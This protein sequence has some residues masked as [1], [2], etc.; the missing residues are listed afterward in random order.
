MEMAVRLRRECCIQYRPLVQFNGGVLR[1]KTLFERFLY[2]YFP[3]LY[4]LC[5]WIHPCVWQRERLSVN[6][7]VGSEMLTIYRYVSEWDQRRS[8]GI[9]FG[10]PIVISC[11]VSVTYVHKLS[12]DD[13]GTVFR[14]AFLP[15]K[16]LQLRPILAHVHAPHFMHC[17][18]ALLPRQ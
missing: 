13:Y 17:I 14:L 7:V 3:S 10:W 11:I 4:S 8:A 6:P 16:K 18:G 1:E 12:Y 15:I 9:V 2:L 5:H